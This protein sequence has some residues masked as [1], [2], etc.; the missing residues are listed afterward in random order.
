MKL[1]IRDQLC[2][3]EHLLFH[4][5]TDDV[6]LTVRIWQIRAGV[7]ELIERCRMGDFQKVEQEF[8]VLI[9]AIEDV[10]RLADRVQK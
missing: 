4:L 3:V 6:K 1:E 5:E 10:V 8:D 7:R 9:P 2:Q